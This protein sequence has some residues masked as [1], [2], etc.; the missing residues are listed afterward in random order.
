[1]L[2]LMSNATNLSETVMATLRA[3]V[4]GTKGGEGVSILVRRGLV[5]ETV[6]ARPYYR[7]NRRGERIL[8]NFHVRSYAITP[9]GI[10]AAK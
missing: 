4:D 7:T 8:V 6:D 2:C 1:M 3:M 10:E 9:A 5:D